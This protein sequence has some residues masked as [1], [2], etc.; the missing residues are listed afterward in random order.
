V[1]RVSLEQFIQDK[2]DRG[3]FTE[4][5][6]QIEDALNRAFEGRIYQRYNATAAP[7]GSTVSWQLGDIV[8]NTTPTES[9][10]A[11]SKYMIAGWMCVA[12]G[13]PGTWREMRVLTGN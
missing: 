9:G 5:I 10:S 7:T 12:A 4:M 1:P 8:Y 11:G 3:S 13:A 2:Y 6:R